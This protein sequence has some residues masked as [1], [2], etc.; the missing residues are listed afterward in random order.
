MDTNQR[1][2]NRR[3]FLEASLSLAAAAGLNACGSEPSDSGSAASSSPASDGAGSS[4]EAL[5]QGLNA[6]DFIV[7]GTNPWTLES[8]RS[9]LGAGIT[10]VNKMFVRGNLPFPDA[11]ILND[12]NAWKVEIAGVKSPRTMTVGELK[13]LGEVKVPAVLQCSGNGRK[14]FKHGPSG[15]PWGVGAAANVLWTGVPL[16]KVIEAA[17]GLDG[18]GMRF[19][20]GTGGEEIPAVLDERDAIV[21]RSIPL[22]KA[23][24]DAILAWDLNEEPID[25]A[26]GGP[27][28]LVVPGYYGV[29][30]VKYLK[31]LSASPVETDAKIQV[32]SYRVRPIGVSGGPDQPSM[33][34]M[35]V[36]S[37]ITSPLGGEH[38]AAGKQKV[39]CIAFCGSSEVASVEISVDGGESWI[40]ASPF[41]PSLGGYSWTQYSIDWTPTSGRYTLACRATD[42][43]GN[44]QPKLRAENERGYAHNGWLD[45]SVSV[46]IA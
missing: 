45:P 42:A 18:D 27:I 12:R 22:E 10:P 25:L 21:E 24:R 20:T 23:M 9:E 8:K 46:D 29:N 15:S 4:G 33:Y 36:K 41:G 7:H 44:V 17:G 11:S 5:P 43:D 32:A 1:P 37:W 31:R 28:R 3:T 38:L 30:N 2:L 19:I 34:D 26:H 16:S 13:T 14:F 35:N 40:E 39:T 6:D